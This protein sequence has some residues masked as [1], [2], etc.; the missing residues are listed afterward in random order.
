MKMADKPILV[1]GGQRTSLQKRK[2]KMQKL[3]TSGVKKMNDSSQDDRV[4]SAT[5]KVRFCTPL[6]FH[7]NHLS[8]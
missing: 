3:K 4:E 8:L 2:R 5:K 6:C 7:M 1:T